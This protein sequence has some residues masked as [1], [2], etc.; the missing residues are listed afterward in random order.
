MKKIQPGTYNKVS[1]SRY[2][3]MGQLSHTFL[4]RIIDHSKES[5]WTRGRQKLQGT[6]FWACQCTYTHGLSAVAKTCTKLVKY[7]KNSQYGWEV[8]EQELSFLVEKALKKKKNIFRN[9]NKFILPP[10][11]LRSTVPPF[12]TLYS[13]SQAVSLFSS[14]KI[15]KTMESSPSCDH[16]ACF[17]KQLIYLVSLE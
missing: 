3:L 8:G 15:N 11:T 6:V 1:T 4:L 7:Q 14:S 2:P 5:P 16:G 13:P 12:S 17:S 9:L 10:L